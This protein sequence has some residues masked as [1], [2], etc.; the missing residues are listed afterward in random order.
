MFQ[1][2][3]GVGLVLMSVLLLPADILLM[4]VYVVHLIKLLYSI[5]IAKTFT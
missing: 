1:K 3:F 2:P 5:V 4:F